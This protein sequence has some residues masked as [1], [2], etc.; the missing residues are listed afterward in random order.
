M[1]PTSRG[2]LRSSTLL[3]ACCAVLNAC[4]GEPATR[5]PSTLS[6]L[7]RGD[8][9]LLGPWGPLPQQYLV[10]LPLFERSF[11]ESPYQ[12]SE[13]WDVSADG[14]TWT[15]H[16]R[17][18]ARWQDGVP[19]TAED[20]AFTADL[21]NDPAVTWRSGGATS[22]EVLDERT[23]RFQ[24]HRSD[25]TWNIETVYPKHLLED[26]DPAEFQSWPFWSD[27]VGS[28]AYRYGLV[29][30]GATLDL[31]A[32][33][34]WAGPPPPVERF[35]FRFSGQPVV[36]LQAGEI[37][38]AG[39]R[40]VVLLAQRTPELHVRVGEGLSGHT[41]IW[42]NHNHPPLDD[43][44]VRRALDMAVDRREVMRLNELPDEVPVV[45]VPLTG[46]QWRERS[47]PAP[48]AH[49][50]DRARALLAEA[51]WVDTDGDG[52]VEKAGRELRL[53]FNVRQDAVD[54]AV[55]VQSQLSQA[56]VA[57]EV[58]VMEYNASESRGRRG[59]A[60]ARFG[61]MNGGLPW[62]AENLL[63]PV[64][65]GYTSPELARLGVLAATTFLDDVEDEAYRAAWEILRRDV[66]ITLVRPLIGLQVIH[67]DAL[68][69]WDRHRTEYRGRRPE[70]P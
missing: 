29:L 8:E 39:G 7:V 14:R 34:A 12:L 50:L 47:F 31:I 44:R 45:D 41:M 61:P 46:R 55:L 5:E 24:L 42:W 16:L 67:E 43:V 51:G 53:D 64:A 6:Q 49:D 62:I 3:F 4:Q 11:P 18:D 69:L 63:D 10:F 1:R 2:I 48:V 70:E 37:D 30:P 54:D 20:V 59:L 15:F 27:P 21:F 22:L 38:L 56:G 35:R 19:V 52:I 57:V 68:E 65:T 32:D 40:D 13:S 17:E 60:D 26:L 9:R 66:P 28:G 58:Q 36:L 33:S 23:V 25:W